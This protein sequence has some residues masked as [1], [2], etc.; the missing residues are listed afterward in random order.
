LVWHVRQERPNPLLDGLRVRLA[1]HI[2]FVSHANRINRFGRAGSRLQKA[3]VIY[4]VVDPERFRPT[5]DIATAKSLVNLDPERLTLTF[6]GNL[7]PRK[8]PEWVL[9]A[10]AEL[11][12][13]FPLQVLLVGAPLGEPTY[14]AE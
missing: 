12:S 2:V 6:V 3:G 13:E 7:F 14:L 8:R 10:S 4:N 11:Q 9:R 5:V 1:S